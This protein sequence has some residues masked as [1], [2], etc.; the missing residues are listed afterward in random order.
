MGPFDASRSFPALATRP[1]IIV[2]GALDGRNPLGGVE[3]VVTRTRKVFESQ[4]K[5]SDTFMYFLD[6]NAVHEYTPLMETQANAFLDKWLL[7][8]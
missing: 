2:N 7:R 5:P 3:Q 1:V 4:G 6:P 8:K